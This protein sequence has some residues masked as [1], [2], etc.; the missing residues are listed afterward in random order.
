M[1]NLEKLRA[2]H[3]RL[4]QK[5]NDAVA[6]ALAAIGSSAVQIARDTKIVKK[7]SGAMS[8]GW[9]F[10]IIRRSN[11]CVVKFFN[12]VQHALHQEIGTGVFGPNRAPYE[13]K[14][15][16]AKALRFQTADGSI[17]FRRRVIHY[18]VH[19]RYIGRAAMY[20][21]EAMFFGSD[22]ER[23]TRLIN[24]WLTNASK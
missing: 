3:A 18:G 13:I 1:F 2:E 9:A 4:I 14:A 12:N 24:R 5:K 8:S 7:R 17:V 22:H 11:S 10:R 23:D 6:G 20:G 21:H 19:P 16:R 15:V